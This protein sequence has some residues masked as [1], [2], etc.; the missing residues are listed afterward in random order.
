MQ[1]SLRIGFLAA[2]AVATADGAAHAQNNT[3]SFG[4]W[5]NV[6]LAP[7]SRRPFRIPNDPDLSFII[8]DGS[9][10]FAYLACSS[11]GP[12]QQRIVNSQAL[13]VGNGR[14]LFCSTTE[15]PA[16]RFDMLMGQD[17]QLYC[18]KGGAAHYRS[19]SDARLGV[20]ITWVGDRSPW[21]LRAG[22]SFPWMVS[23]VVGPL[24]GLIWPLWIE[25]HYETVDFA[26]AFNNS[27]NGVLR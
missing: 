11:E 7:I 21:T 10:G 17:G 22:S 16:F 9:T 23:P 25:I 19:A 3:T 4:P 14:E 12:G 20:A 1:T 15:W 24:G 8:N 26:P 5:T 27:C 2:C 13:P 6:G 18:W